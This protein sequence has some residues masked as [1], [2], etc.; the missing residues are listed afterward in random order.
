MASLLHEGGRV[1]LAAPGG[2]GPHDGVMQARHKICQVAACAA[3]CRQ[4]AVKPLLGCKLIYV[5]H[6]LD[7]HLRTGHFH[8]EAE[9]RQKPNVFSGRG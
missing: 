8:S 5:A 1:V 9:P 3:G 6:K 4:A 2:T 7:R